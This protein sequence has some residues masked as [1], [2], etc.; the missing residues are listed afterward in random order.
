LAGD[1]EELAN[2]TRG[3]LVGARGYLRK[4]ARL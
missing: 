1:Y 4:A 3:A 2:W